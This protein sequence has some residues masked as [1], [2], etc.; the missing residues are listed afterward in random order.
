ML[1]TSFKQH[2]LKLIYGIKIIKAELR[3]QGVLAKSN[4][5]MNRLDISAHRRAVQTSLLHRGFSLTNQ[6]SQVIAALQQARDCQVLET[7]IIS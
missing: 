5:S 3:W 2:T 4:Q 1:G 7:I 6:L